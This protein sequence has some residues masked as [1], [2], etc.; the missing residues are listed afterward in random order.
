[1]TPHRGIS[2]FPAWRKAGGRSRPPKATAGK[3]VIRTMETKTIEEALAQWSPAIELDARKA[4]SSHI[5]WYCFAVEARLEKRPIVCLAELY[6]SFLLGTGDGR[7]I[8][9][10]A[11]D[12]CGPLESE[13][14]RAAS[15]I[16]AA[17]GRLACRRAEADMNALFLEDGRFRE[18][19]LECADRDDLEDAIRKA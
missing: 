7:S 17:A 12:M 1:M 5:D 8:V 16:G 9:S 13:P 4:A 10:R 19:M 3:K 6:A 11:L 14:E 18:R 2:P 15:A